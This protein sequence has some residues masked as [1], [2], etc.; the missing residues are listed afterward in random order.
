MKKRKLITIGVLL[1]SL[2]LSGCNSET[3]PELDKL[4]EGLPAAQIND[5]KINFSP[6]SEEENTTPYSSVTGNVVSSSSKEITVKYDG[7][8][9]KFTVDGDTKI[10][11]G[12]ITVSEAVTVTYEGDLS[13]KKVTAKIITVLSE[14]GEAETVSTEEAVSTAEPEAAETTAADETTAQAE[15]APPETASAISETT[16][17]EAAADTAEATTAAE[18]TEATSTQETIPES[19]IN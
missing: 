6:V 1:L 13:D 5:G 7:K 19:T 14:N 12:E 11:G 16:I 17:S 15:T 8:D 2:L 10:F 9:Y 4:I 18:Q 3:D